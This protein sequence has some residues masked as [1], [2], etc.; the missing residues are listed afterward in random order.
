MSKKKTLP[1]RIHKKNKLVYYLHSYLSQLLPT[2]DAEKEIM[3]LKKKLSLT[4][5]KIAEERAN[6]YCKDNTKMSE[7]KS[8]KTVSDLK[9]AVTPKSYFFDTYDIAKFYDTK[10]AVDYVFGD[11]THVPT[12]PSIVKSRP[13]S[14]NNQNSVLLNLDKLRHFVFVEDEKQLEDKKSLL[15]GRGAV[16]QAHR[17][18]F[19]EKYFSHPLCNLGQVNKIGGNPLW[20]KEKMKIKDHLDYRF[21]LSLQGNDVA[22][23]LKWILSS[24]SLAVQPKPTLE[25]WFMEGKLVGDEH[26]IQIK[27]DYS[28]LETKLIEYTNNMK[29]AKEVANNAKMFC[30]QFANPDLEKLCALLVLK[31]YFSEN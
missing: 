3:I 15:I 27:E 2:K 5:C 31:K 25:T 20:I 28:D 13:I 8:G 4:D 10:L 7:K 18:Q 12:S 21:I 6:Y 23:N 19:Y 9:K 16:Y 22:T 14:D 24:N 29:K 17:I 11:V 1:F 26:Y 30:K